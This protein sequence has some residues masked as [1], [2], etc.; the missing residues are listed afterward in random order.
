M[1][2][3]V[4]DIGGTN[5]RCALAAPSGIGPFSCYRNADFPDLATLLGRH[6]DG[7]PPARR[8][9][10][11]A[12]AIAAPIRGDEVRMSNIDWRFSRPALRTALALDELLLV[13]DFAALARALPEL[14]PA[15]LAAVGGGRP[16]PDA[17]RIVLGPGTGL[18]V[19]A[20]VRVGGQWAGLPGEGGHVTLGSC[21]D[22][23]EA[24]LRAARQRYGHCSAERILS[25]H[26]LS[27]LH[28]T[29]HGGAARPAEAIGAGL[30]DGEPAAVASFGLFFGL[31]GNM[32][33][34][35]A[36]TLGAFGGV[37]I[38]GGIVPRYLDHLARSSFRERFEAKGRF[39]GYLRDIPTWVITDPVP[40]LKGLAALAGDRGLL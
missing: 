16:V 22:Q 20:L 21:T 10:L 24:V 12:L 3:L 8:P 39:R 30:A 4:A 1:T 15:D 35:L 2:L 18:G 9:R 7:L 33:G 17:P 40:A 28:E 27:F 19:A 26:G 23:E 13:N 6:L 11:A 5:T 34:N 38:A 14:A 31:L 37:Y 32:A 25:G 36:L 29:L